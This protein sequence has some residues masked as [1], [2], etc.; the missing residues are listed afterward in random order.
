MA[1]DDPHLQTR[2]KRAL[3]VAGAIGVAAIAWNADDWWGWGDNDVRIEV[4]DREE[5]REVARQVRDEVRESVREAR[6][7][8]RSARA[9]ARASAGADGE[10][11]AAR[12]ELPRITEEGGV[13]RVESPDGRSVTISIDDDTAQA[14]D[15]ADAAEEA[16]TTDE[17]TPSTN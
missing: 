1:E 17:Q 5:A 9:S 6:D 2:R 7:E 16:E 14:P 4:S 8:A 13:L 11:D 15:A 12:D 3:L 10:T